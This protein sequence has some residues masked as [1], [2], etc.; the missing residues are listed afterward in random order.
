MDL[1][2]FA[3]LVAAGCISAAL[4][5]IAI[6]LATSI[7]L[8]PAVDSITNEIY[9]SIESKINNIKIECEN[10]YNPNATEITLNEEKFYCQAKPKG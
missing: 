8:R 6:L 5:A 9:S 4:A 1:N 7:Y 3:E 2:K 10:Q